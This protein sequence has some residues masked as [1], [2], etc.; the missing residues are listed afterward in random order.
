MAL[1]QN[2]TK[3][4]KKGGQLGS[5]K[6]EGV[7]SGRKKTR[8]HPIESKKAVMVL[9]GPPAPPAPP[10]P[11][12]DAPPKE[13]NPVEDSGRDFLDL[14]FLPFFDELSSSACSPSLASSLTSS[15]FTS[16]STPSFFAAAFLDVFL[17]GFPKKPSRT[18]G[19]LGSAFSSTSSFL[20]S[21]S[22]FLASFLSS[23]GSFEGGGGVVAEDGGLSR[24]EGGG[25]G[26]VEV[27]PPVEGGEIDGSPGKDP[28]C[29]VPP[30]IPPFPI[31]PGRSAIERCWRRERDRGKEEDE[32]REEEE[33]EEEEGRVEKDRIEEGMTDDEVEGAI[34]D[35][36]EIERCEMD[37]DD[38]NLREVVEDAIRCMIGKEKGGRGGGG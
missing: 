16:S 8:T 31:P 15:S 28:V 37:T 35:R 14:P 3:R 17:S 33:E 25:G 26:G 19:A 18:K 6:A 38:A 10:D 2:E 5:R 32:R 22:S 36:R 34:E 7:A 11:V 24:E 4:T 12:P 27:G 13:K 9:G 30:M 23:L 29:F 20:E 1:H 21:S